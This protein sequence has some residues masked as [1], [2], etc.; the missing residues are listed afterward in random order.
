MQAGQ[1]GRGKGLDSAD[2]M[3][4][5]IADKVKKRDQRQHSSARKEPASSSKKAKGIETW[6]RCVGPPAH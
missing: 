5:E 4:D 6:E 3:P 2:F 1:E